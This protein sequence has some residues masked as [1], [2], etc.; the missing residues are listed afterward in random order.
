[1]CPLSPWAARLTPVCRVLRE[2]LRG[3]WPGGA[4]VPKSFRADR[5]VFGLSQASWPVL[6]SGS[7]LPEAPGYCHLSRSPDAHVPGGRQW[8]GLRGTFCLGPP[9]FGCRVPWCGPVHVTSGALPPA[10]H[11]QRTCAP[12]LRRGQGPPRQSLAE[13]RRARPSGLSLA[14]SPRAP[15][16]FPVAGVVRVMATTPGTGGPSPG[17][18]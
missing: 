7:G 15:L 9:D 11:T 8:T 14:A 12:A 4:S 10:T 18:H 1:M 6:W 2:G 5:F 16:P 17:E 3:E 13:A